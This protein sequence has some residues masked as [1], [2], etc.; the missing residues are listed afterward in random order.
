[1]TRNSKK[2]KNEEYFF[3]PCQELVGK[4]VFIMNKVVKRFGQLTECDHLGVIERIT[5]HFLYIR[6]CNG[7]LIKWSDIHVHFYPDK[8]IVDV[9]WNIKH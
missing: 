9:Q 1:M 6:N 7:V 3:N 5:D 4:Y 8:W 2:I